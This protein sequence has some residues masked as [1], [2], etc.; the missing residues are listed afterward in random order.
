MPLAYQEPHFF[1][2]LDEVSRHKKILQNVFPFLEKT[3]KECPDLQWGQIAFCRTTKILPFSSAIEAMRIGGA[4]RF[5]A[6][7]GTATPWHVL[8]VTPYDETDPELGVEFSFHHLVPQL[9]PTEDSTQ[10]MGVPYVLEESPVTIP[11]VL[12]AGFGWQVWLPKNE[13]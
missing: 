5:V 2:C 9:H 8:V 7:D 12:I 13:K 6:K 1:L 4:A 10:I 11:T 3:L